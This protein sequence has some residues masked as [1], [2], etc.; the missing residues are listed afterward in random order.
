MI[1]LIVV[2]VVGG[3]FYAF[4]KLI[5][6]SAQEARGPIYATKPVVRGDVEVA[7]TATGPLNPTQ[8]GGIVVPGMP[9]P[10]PSPTS[11]VIEEVLA[12]DGDAVRQGQVLVRLSGADL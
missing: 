11:Y 3:G 10:G 2:T 6:P 7:V 1:A 4:R 5:P 8:G 9:M 12:K